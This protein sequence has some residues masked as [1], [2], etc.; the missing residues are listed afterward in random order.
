MYQYGD[1]HTTLITEILLI[2][3]LTKKKKKHFSRHYQVTHLLKHRYNILGQILLIN[4]KIYLFCM[5]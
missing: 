3:L 5:V 2:F 4:L 1:L